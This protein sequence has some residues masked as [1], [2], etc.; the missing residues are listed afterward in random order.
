M[1]ATLFRTLLDRSFRR[2]ARPILLS[3]CAIPMLVLVCALWHF[4]LLITC[5]F[6]WASVHVLHQIAYILVC[7]DSRRGHLPQRWAQYIDYAVIFSS[8]YPFAAYRFMH[9][10]F[11]IGDTLLLYPEFLKTP[12]LCYGVAGFFSLALLL[13]LGKTCWEIRQGTAHYPKLALMSVTILCALFIT[14][15]SGA[16]LEIAFQGLNTWH[17]VQYLA[18]TWHVSARRWQRSDRSCHVMR[19]WPELRI[20]HFGVFYALN[21]AFTAGALLLIGLVFRYSALPFEHCYYIVVL[22]FLLIHYYYDHILFTQ[23]EAWR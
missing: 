11:Y 12:M 4:P 13:F 1:F 17:S 14:S 18:L 16:K 20:S 22:S 9:D 3:S 10:E 7:Y 5:F 8:L 15:Y 6:F 19:R 21:I 2:T 23:F